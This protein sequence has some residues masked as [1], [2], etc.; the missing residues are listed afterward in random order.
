MNIL[1]ETDKLIIEHDF[2]NAYLLEKES[3]K[4]LMYDD[5][6][7]NPTCGLISKHND[8]AIIAGEHLTLW[9]NGRIEKNENEELKWTNSIRIKRDHIVEILTDPW[10][11]NSAIWELDLKTLE[12]K[13][14]R[15]F[16]DYR[17]QD[18]CN[19]VIW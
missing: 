16:P 2:E 17:E 4:K 15:E 5:F 1:Y 8:W 13:K 3:G 10:S 18:Y 19:E 7:G 9:I 6:Y 11:E 14:I 12:Y